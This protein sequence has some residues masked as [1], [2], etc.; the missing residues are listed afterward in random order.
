MGFNIKQI[1]WQQV[2]FCITISADVSEA[3]TQAFRYS[4]I[5]VCKTNRTNEYL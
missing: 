4:R 1:D 3:L 2:Q 5:L